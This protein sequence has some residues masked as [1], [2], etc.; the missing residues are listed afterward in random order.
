MGLFRP[1]VRYRPVSRYPLATATRGGRK[2]FPDTSG[3]ALPAAVGRGIKL[4]KPGVGELELLLGREAGSPEA[5][6]SEVALLIRSGVAR[7]I[8]VSLGR[9]GVI[10][11]SGCGR[12][13]GG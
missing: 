2:F 6:G 9:E 13:L 4:L 10:F 11:C 12:R 1:N 5:Q 3:P 7:T 8:A